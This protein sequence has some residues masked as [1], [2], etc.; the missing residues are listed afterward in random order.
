M[1]SAV[2]TNQRRFMCSGLHFK[3][4][5]LEMEIGNYPTKTIFCNAKNTKRRTVHKA[6]RL[7]GRQSRLTIMMTISD[8]C[9]HIHT[10]WRT[11]SAHGRNPTLPW[12][13]RTLKA[14]PQLVWRV[15]HID[16]NN[17]LPLWYKFRTYQTII[18]AW[19][20]PLRIVPFWRK[21]VSMIGHGWFLKISCWRL[22]LAWH[23][24]KSL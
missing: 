24:K 21:L 10:A 11:M 2:K 15:A 14:Y 18:M 5:V 4:N 20:L 12:L 9:F 19:R 7:W 23:K 16:G 22:A 8:P 1:W 6:H 17:D 13:P 3:G